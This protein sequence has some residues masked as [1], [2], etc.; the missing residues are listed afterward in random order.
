MPL[1]TVGASGR[2]CTG[3][4]TQ[5]SACGE[6]ENN[7]I[8]ALGISQ[9]RVARARLFA[10][11]QRFSGLEV[12]VTVTLLCTCGAHAAVFPASIE[13]SPVAVA[14]TPLVRW[15]S[16]PVVPNETAL[17]HGSFLDSVSRWSVCAASSSQG[18]LHTSTAS[19]TCVDVTPAQLSNLESKVTVPSTF[20][21]DVFHV[22]GCA[23]SSLV[24]NACPVLA[25]L[26]QPVVWW[27][28]GDAGD[29]AS[30]GGW[31]ALFG[32]SLAH[33]SDK[34]CVRSQTPSN[35]TGVRVRLT[36]L[37]NSSCHG[38]DC[39]SVSLV[40]VAYDATCFSL[41]LRL[42]DTI[43]VGSYAVAIDSG[44]PATA[45]F[46]PLPPVAPGVDATVRVVSGWTWPSKQF[47]VDGQFGGNIS[48]A[49]AAA[50]AIGGGEVLLGAH[51]YRM[52]DRAE[53]HLGDGV[54]LSGRG[55][56]VTR[57]VWADNA[58][59]RAFPSRVQRCVLLVRDSPLSHCR[60]LVA[61]VPAHPLISSNARFR[62]RGFTVLMTSP[63]Y[64][65]LGVG[66]QS[67]KSHV[68]FMNFTQADGIVR[69][70]AG[71]DVEGFGYVF[72]NNYMVHGANVCKEVGRL[73]CCV[74]RR[75]RALPT[76]PA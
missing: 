38:G 67:T 46:W 57:L 2:K 26:N 51:E 6:F 23:G 72:S 54:T 44:L 14:Q 32:R 10:T 27:T 24:G 7:V 61:D 70:G 41:R 74:A 42:P 64:I 31:V 35:T 39:A 21:N 37:T 40:L 63:T 43:P 18:G 36:P 3:N 34:E 13:R 28:Q 9:D 29:A 65:I 69:T 5:V 58:G 17:L 19:G 25:T 20:T 12:L 62:V 4:P 66:P 1:R 76:S 11:M 47:D 56:M 68:S 33:G 71:F 16:H 53:L 55:R 50:G 60:S 73:G 75:C 15:A 59:E 22:R 45:T 30:P 52:E 8:C 48:A 49:L